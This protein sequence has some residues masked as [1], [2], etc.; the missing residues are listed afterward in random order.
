MATRIPVCLHA[1]NQTQSTLV[2]LTVLSVSL[3]LQQF[4]EI[5]QAS[6][7]NVL[8]SVQ[9][10][11]AAQPQLYETCSFFKAENSYPCKDIKHKKVMPNKNPVSSST[12]ETK[13]APL[14]A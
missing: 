3:F 11:R 7:N 10:I 12:K 14:A 5:H 1:A 8:N 2:S 6:T 4:L 9:G 13:A